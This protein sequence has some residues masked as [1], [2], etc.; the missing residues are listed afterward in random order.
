[1]RIVRMIG[2]ENLLYKARKRIGIASLIATPFLGALSTANAQTF[3]FSLDVPGAESGK[4]EPGVMYR[5]VVR[6]DST[7]SSVSAKK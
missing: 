4:I 6:G 3:D 1:M 2:L 7:D 5:L